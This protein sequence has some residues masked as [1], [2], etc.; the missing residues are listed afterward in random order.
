MLDVESQEFGLKPMNC[1][2]HCLI[3]DSMQRS[4]KELPLRLAEFGVLHRNEL[5]GALT[6]LLRVRRF[7]QDDAHIFCRKDQISQEVESC[8]DFLCY[9]YDAFGFNYEFELS[10]KPAKALGNADLWAEAEAQLAQALDK[11]GKPWKLN[12]GDGAFYGPKIDI[13]VFD[14]L[15]RKHQ[16]GTIQLDFNLPIRFDLQFKTDHISQESQNLV[17]YDDFKEKPIKTGFERPVIIHRAIL[18]SLERMIA[19]LTEQTGGKWPFWLSPRQIAILPISDH[20]IEYAEKIKTRLVLDGFFADVRAENE[21]LKKKIR[22]AQMQQY[23]LIGV[24]GEHEVAAGTIDVR[25]RDSNKSIGKFTIPDFV[26]FAKS[27]LPAPS[28]ARLQ[29]ESEAYHQESVEVKQVLNFADLNR[30]LELKTYLRGDTVSEDDWSLFAALKTG[31]SQEKYP[32][33][34][35]W[36]LHLKSI[37]A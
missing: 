29:L 15:K 12:P 32:H 36:H 6:G 33:L 9:V 31:P 3:F 24:V 23:N 14:A 26:Q 22:D 16:C 25:D 27:L 21:S 1:P 18:G 19:I 10:T 20:F 13:K 35:R 11:S 2:G 30:E 5:S 28:K 4:Y 34:F 17:E 37:S 7:V 8:L